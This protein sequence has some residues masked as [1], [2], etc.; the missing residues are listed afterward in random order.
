MHCVSDVA[1]VTGVG[2]R[3]DSRTVRAGPIVR[4]VLSRRVEVRGAFVPT[5]LSPDHIGLI[6][7][8][9]TELGFRYRWA[10]E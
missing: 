3:D 6:G 9:F 10:M 5:V 1:G 4:I 8:D 7:G 2:T